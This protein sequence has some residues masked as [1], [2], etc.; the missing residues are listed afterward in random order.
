M[1]VFMVQQ[2]NIHWKYFQYLL[3]GLI[4]LSFLLA[5][6]ILLDLVVGKT[7]CIPQFA[8]FL[9]TLFLIPGSIYLFYKDSEFWQNLSA[10]FT[11]NFL[12]YKHLY[13]ILLMC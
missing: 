7:Y 4:I 9:R 11:S 12:F 8:Y 5:F 3:Y 13:I 10:N 1:A 6:G 2:N